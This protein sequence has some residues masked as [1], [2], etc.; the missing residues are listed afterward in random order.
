MSLPLEATTGIEPAHKSFA[1]SRLT[2]CLRGHT[3]ELRQIYTNL[4]Q[5]STYSPRFL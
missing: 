1:N 5:D 3:F 4:G 2:T